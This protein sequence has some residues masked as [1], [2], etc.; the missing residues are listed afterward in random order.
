MGNLKKY[1]ASFSIFRKQ[2]I[3]NHLVKILKG[4]EEKSTQNN[5]RKREKKL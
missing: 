3:Q 1:D 2:I 4:K 5:E